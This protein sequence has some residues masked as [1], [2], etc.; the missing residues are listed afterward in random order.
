MERREEILRKITNL[1]KSGKIFTNI[2]NVPQQG[3]LDIIEESE[4]IAFLLQ[5]RDVKRGYFCVSKPQVMKSLINN[6]PAG[7]GVEWLGRGIDDEVC[8][9]L[10]ES[11][12]SYYATYLRNGN[13]S[14][15]ESMDKS[16]PL[17]LQKLDCSLFVQEGRVEQI[18]EMHA[19][20]YKHFNP[21]TSHIQT[22]AEL[23][24]NILNNQLKVATA[25]G[26]IVALL[27][28]YMQKKKIYMEH[29]INDGD[30][31]L[32]HALYYS[33]LKEAV[34]NGIN[35]A[36]TWVR[37]SNS[38]ALAFVKRYGLSPDGMKNFVYIKAE[39]CQK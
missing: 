10:L 17:D 4:G 6:F 36:D 34:A 5:D 28:Y 2:F 16:I 26:K 29:M 18:P 21:I 31:H 38:R 37:E 24:E 3:L 12:Y 14:L 11:G 35:V 15:K 20:L 27:T 23:K 30:R 13:Y 1:R 22:E 32:M 39:E 25:D 33:V 9:S 8:D 7:T 19:L